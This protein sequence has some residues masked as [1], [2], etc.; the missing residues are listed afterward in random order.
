[1]R[2]WGVVL[3]LVVATLAV[4]C[5][6]IGFQASGG[7]DGGG[8]DGGDGGMSMSF[9]AQVTFDQSNTMADRATD[10]PTAPKDGE[11]LQIG[12][13]SC[14]GYTGAMMQPYRAILVENA[15]TQPVTVSAWATCIAGDMAV[16][17]FYQRDTPPTT[18]FERA[19]CAIG[20]SERG[21]P[22]PGTATPCP[23]MLAS[24][25]RGLP[26]AVGEK[27]IV[28]IQGEG[29]GTTLPAMIHIEAQ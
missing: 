23:A 20:V 27:A 17:S 15:G 16:I 22:A 11:R 2:G 8:D 4:G 6:R 18:R 5:G 1:M 7:G 25:S 19:Q 28:W 24:S 10:P 12:D 14:P 26:L 21:S 29:S 13:G 9:G 3:R